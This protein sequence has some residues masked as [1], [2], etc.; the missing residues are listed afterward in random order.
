M[1]QDRELT[2]GYDAVRLE[3]SVGQGHYRRRANQYDAMAWS[4]LIWLWKRT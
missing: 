1:A 4:G 2:R 3:I